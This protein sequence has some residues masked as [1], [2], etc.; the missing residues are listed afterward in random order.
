MLM[1]GLLVRIGTPLALGIN[2]SLNITSIAAFPLVLL[3]S[4]TRYRLYDIDIIIRRTLLYSA[5]TLTLAV[6]YFGLV[7]GMQGLFALRY[8]DQPGFVVVLTTLL[9]AALFQPL[10]RRYQ[11]AIDRRFFRSNYNP[12]Q[13]LASFAS[14]L[15]YEVDLDQIQSDLLSIVDETVQPKEAFLWMIKIT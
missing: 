8:G 12:E 11:S 5:L 13:A 2:W 1:D 15:R 6:I 14:H 3:I 10:R 7:L 4:I 9:I